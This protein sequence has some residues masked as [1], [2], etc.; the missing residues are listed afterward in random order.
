MHGM[1]IAFGHTA[2]SPGHGANPAVNWVA[3]I[4][5]SIMLGAIMVGIATAVAG[6]QRPYKRHRD[7]DDA[8]FRGGGGRGGPGPDAPRGP[9]GDPAWWAEFEQ[10]FAAHVAGL[11][12]STTT[13]V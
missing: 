9:Q 4:L 8:D 11:R 1:A 10:Q 3:V 13:W 2:S 7:D 12:R 5:I 6:L